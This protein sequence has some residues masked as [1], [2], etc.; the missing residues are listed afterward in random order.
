M[1]L[2]RSEAPEFDKGPN[3]DEQNSRIDSAAQSSD[4]TIGPYK[5]Q[6]SLAENM[7]LKNVDPLLGEDYERDSFHFDARKQS[8]KL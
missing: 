8:V 2:V 1:V 6:G 7:R 4:F 5:K 3:S